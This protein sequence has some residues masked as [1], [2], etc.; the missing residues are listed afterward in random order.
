MRLPEVTYCIHF[1]KMDEHYVFLFNDK[2][3]A[4]VLGQF[5]LWAMREDLSFSWYDAA[6]LSC[7]VRNLPILIED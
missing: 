4:S 3:V 2:H 7:E 5:G 1:E 6:R